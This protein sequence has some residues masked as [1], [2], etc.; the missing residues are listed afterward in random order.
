MEV[1]RLSHGQGQDG[2]IQPQAEVISRSK[3]HGRS[4]DAGANPYPQKI[5]LDSSQ[6]SSSDHTP[7]SMW[8]HLDL[9]K[10]KGR[11]QSFDFKDI[12][13]GPIH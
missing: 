12:E 10:K 4:S 6:S 13:L 2:S 8:S 1:G 9:M 11:L 5:S 3:S 7:Q